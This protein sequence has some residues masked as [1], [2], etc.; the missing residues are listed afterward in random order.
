ME[1]ASLKNVSSLIREAKK[2][3]I[4]NFDDGLLYNCFEPLSGPPENQFAQSRTRTLAIA[5]R[6]RNIES[7]KYLQDKKEDTDGEY[8][9]P[10]IVNDIF[11]FYGGTDDDDPEA[12]LPDIQT[13]VDQYEAVQMMIKIKSG[14]AKVESSCLE[15]NLPDM[16]KTKREEQYLPLINKSEALRFKAIAYLTSDVFPWHRKAFTLNV[17]GIGK[18]TVK[19]DHN[20]K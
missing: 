6:I 2:Q 8:E 14:N 19:D 11:K 9:D 3:K 20:G 17:P 15:S 7:Q 1:E 10:E 16:I 18:I 4:A 12:I 5:S 13:K